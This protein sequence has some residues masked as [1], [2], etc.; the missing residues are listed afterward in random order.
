MS[1][2]SLVRHIA[3]ARPVYARLFCMMI[4][5]MLI[6]FSV[7]LAGCGGSGGGGEDLSV[8]GN[9]P[10]RNVVDDQGSGDNPYYV[11]T[12]A[13]AVFVQEDENGEM[14]VGPKAPPKKMRKWHGG[15][16][17]SDPA[18]SATNVSIALS[19]QGRA[20]ITWIESDATNSPAALVSAVYEM[21]P[22]L[23]TEPLTKSQI[24]IS[25]LSESGASVGVAAVG[26]PARASAFVVQPAAKLA[27]NKS[28]DA[29]VAWLQRTNNMDSFHLAYMGE[30]SQQW[31]VLPGFSSETGQISGF[32]LLPLPNGDVFIV[33]REAR[34]DASGV[35][36]ALTTSA[37]VGQVF[38]VEAGV[39]E[40]PFTLATGVSASEAPALWVAHGV[41]YVAYVLDDGV[42][43]IMSGA[44]NVETG[45]MTLSEAIGGTGHKTALQG[46]HINNRHVLIWLEADDY[47]FRSAYAS[48]SQ[49]SMEASPNVFWESTRLLEVSPGHLSQLRLVTDGQRGQ[50]FWANIDESVYGNLY[51]AEF[52]GAQFMAPVLLHEQGADTPVA[53]YD[54]EGRVYLM[55]RALHNYYRE[56]HPERGWRQ[57]QRNFCV[58]RS[59]GLCYEG[60]REQTIQVTQ[61]H[62]LAAWRERQARRDVI[63]IALNFRNEPEQ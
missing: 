6:L 8:D 32:Y 35:S 14:F 38:R 3:F 52:D 56:F 28:G 18:R 61:R 53:D 10:P 9:E 17:L 37:F 25:Q 47:G 54:D 58:Q 42:N 33:R 57:A 4:F 5:S 30:A 59:F 16:V 40:A 51:A 19:E 34:A 44:V 1:A 26:L 15:L 50:V 55:W 36:A 2:G 27:M 7:F 21:P 12:H 49:S 60:G 43:T 20:V 31:Q 46:A 13:E 41:P 62:G 48:V 24:Q 22:T 63:A 11:V 39:Y 29:F 23:P 45:V